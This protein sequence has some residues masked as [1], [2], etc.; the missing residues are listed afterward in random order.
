MS[1][2]HHLDQDCD[3]MSLAKDH[4]RV[5][6]LRLHETS[7]K[8]HTDEARDAIS[9]LSN[10]IDDLMSDFDVVLEGLVREAN[11]SDDVIEARHRQ[12]LMRPW[13]AE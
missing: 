12:S 7:Q 5:L 11:R 2:Q 10:Q 1:M 3:S 9:D 8:L 13:A 4:V 6:Q